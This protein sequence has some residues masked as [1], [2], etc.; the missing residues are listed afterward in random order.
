MPSV[1][2]ARRLAFGPG[3]RNRQNLARTPHHIPEL[4]QYADFYADMTDRFALT[5]NLSLWRDISE[6]LHQLTSEPEDVT[7]R[8]VTANG[9]PAILVMP[10]D[11]STEHILLHSHS[12]GS[13]T[14]SMWQ[15]RKAVGHLAKAAGSRALVIN[16]RLAPE[17][18]YSIGG[19]YAANLALTLQRKKAPLRGQCCRPR[20]GSTW[21]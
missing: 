2:D 3:P 13:V 15:E 4:A 12:G 10:A 11:S 5:D 7:Y 1:C 6:R 18:K 21:N 19:N 14:A 20:R 9:V 8:D 16:Y 17:D